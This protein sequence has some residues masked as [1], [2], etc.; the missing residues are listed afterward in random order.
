MPRTHYAVHPE[1]QHE[2]PLRFP[3]NPHLELFVTDR[4]VQ[5][6]PQVLLVLVQ[7]EISE[8]TTKSWAGSS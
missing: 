4:V 8:S 2:Q 5:R 3:L 1:Q 6:T 7:S